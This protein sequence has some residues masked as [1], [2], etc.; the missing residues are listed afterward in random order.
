MAVKKEIVELPQPLNFI[1]AFQPSRFVVTQN[2]GEFYLTVSAGVSSVSVPLSIQNSANLMS[3]ITQMNKAI[4][5]TEKV[6]K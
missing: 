6:Y 2:K 5:A 1:S 3:W 4:A